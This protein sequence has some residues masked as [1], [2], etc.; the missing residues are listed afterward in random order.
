MRVATGRASEVSLSVHEVDVAVHEGGT[1]DDAGIV[2]VMRLIERASADL[3]RWSVTLGAQHV[4]D[5]WLDSCAQW[6]AGVGG[7]LVSAFSYGDG[8]ERKIALALAAEESSMRLLMGME[9]EGK[10]TISVLKNLD[11]NAARAA[12]ELAAR[13][14]LADRILQARL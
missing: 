8:P 10:E 2:M 9:R 1:A 7:T 11:G 6:V 5:G 12:G 3:D 13:I 14:E 4:C